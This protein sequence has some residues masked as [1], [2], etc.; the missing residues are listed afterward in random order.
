MN[1]W[2]IVVGNTKEHSEDTIMKAA[3]IYVY[4]CVAAKQ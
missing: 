3:T 4:N 2:L 1:D